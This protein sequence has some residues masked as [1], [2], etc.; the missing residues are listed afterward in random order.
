[1]RIY[2]GAVVNP[3]TLTESQL[4]PRCL[5][6]VGDAGTIEWI[7]E[8]VDGSLVQETLA[9]KGCVDAEVS[10]LRHGEFL[11]PGFVDTHTHAPQKPN[12]GR[13]VTVLASLP[14]F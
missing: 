2:Y 11:M 6:A 8:D 9:Q 10:E 7:V 13:C 14:S 1:M 5:L 4:L 3:Q 12:I